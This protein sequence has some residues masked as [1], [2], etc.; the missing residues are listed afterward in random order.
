MKY[1]DFPIKEATPIAVEKIIQE[2]IARVP[3][4]IIQEAAPPVTEEM[5]EAKTE[6]M[7]D[8]PTDL[9]LTAKQWAQSLGFRWEHVSGFLHFQMKNLGRELRLVH[10]DWQ[11]LWDAYMTRPVK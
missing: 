5:L 11:A 2:A 4:K 3:E 1:N 8:A 10:N 6:S 7:G 9:P